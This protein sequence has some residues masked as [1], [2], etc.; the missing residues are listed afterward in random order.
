MPQH[1]V[2][3]GTHEDHEPTPCRIC[4]SRRRTRNR[5]PAPEAWAQG[6]ALICQSCGAV[7]ANARAR[8][9]FCYGA[10]I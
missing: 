1:R 9:G 6:P 2:L 8:R 10:G 4:G 7:A 5:P 3:L